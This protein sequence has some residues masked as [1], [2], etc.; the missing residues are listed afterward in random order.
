[1]LN[2]KSLTDMLSLFKAYYEA[3]K[4][5]LNTII[6]ER[7]ILEGHGEREKSHV[8]RNRTFLLKTPAVEIFWECHVKSLPSK[9]VHVE[10]GGLS[11]LEVAAEEVA[12]SHISGVLEA[13]FQKHAAG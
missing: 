13:R 2:C 6:F 11:P 1:M 5:A 10:V 12:A 4:E 8:K 7:W 3:P 9:G